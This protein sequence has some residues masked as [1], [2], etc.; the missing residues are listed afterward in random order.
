[1]SKTHKTIPIGDVNGDGQPD[2]VHVPLYGPNGQPVTYETMFDDVET[3]HV[4]DPFEKTNI[5]TI[6]EFLAKHGPVL[7]KLFL[8]IGSA[9][10]TGYNAWKAS[11][12][13][14]VAVW[15][16][17]L[18]I[19]GFCGLIVEGGFA[20]G[21]S[22][23]GSKKLAGDQVA[24]ADKIFKRSAY[25]MMGDLSLSVGEIAFG[26]HGIA[27]FWIGVLQPF[28]AVHVIMLYYRLKGESPEAQA[29]QEIVTLKAQA[30]ADDIRDRSETWKGHLMDRKNARQIEAKARTRRHSYALKLVSGFWYGRRMRQEVKDYVGKEQLGNGLKQK[31]KLLPTSLKNLKNRNN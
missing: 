8:I 27:Q 5:D 31:L 13:E 11:Q 17:V 21:W 20:Y 3:N 30:R 29:E 24:T 12:M 4:T 28:V 7:G 2:T 9:S 1:M 22:V 14:A 16:L 25:T 18:A 10:A 23:R 19:L 15:W 26:I 6:P